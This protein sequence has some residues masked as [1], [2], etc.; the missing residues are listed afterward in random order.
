MAI[1]SLIE[2]CP[3]KGLMTFH[4]QYTSSHTDKI[5][6][7]KWGKKVNW[8]QKLLLAVKIFEHFVDMWLVSSHWLI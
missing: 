7:R 2:E 3:R 5:L 4:Y 6:E 1:F 8:N